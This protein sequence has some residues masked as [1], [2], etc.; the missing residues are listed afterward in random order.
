MI[1]PSTFEGNGVVAVRFIPDSAFL[2]R[3]LIVRAESAKRGTQVHRMPYGWP[4]DL[5]ENEILSRLLSLNLSRPGNVRQQKKR[6]ACGR[7]GTMLNFLSIAHRNHAARFFRKPQRVEP[8][9][10]PRFF[11]LLVAIAATTWNWFAPSTAEEPA[12]TIELRV[13]PAR[14][15]LTGKGAR[16]G[17]IVSS[18]DGDG[19]VVDATREAAFQ[20]DR[21]E[22]VAVSKRGECVAVA[23][24]KAEISV[25]F[26]GK[27]ASVLVE[28]RDAEKVG[29]PSFVNEIEPLFTRFGCNQGACHGKLAGQNGFRLSLRAYAPS[30][31]TSGSR[32]NTPDDA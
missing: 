26:G 10:R 6:P 17:L 30:K 23:N 21:P 22:I 5:A 27:T 3:P 13:E 32:M 16:H 14:I 7:P 8:T 1:D 15:E 28:A 18:I 29:S 2:D 9:M 31:I 20:S 24:G 12:K 11:V 4:A 25:S 19:R